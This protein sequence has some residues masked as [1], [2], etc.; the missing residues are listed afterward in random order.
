MLTLFREVE[1]TTVALETHGLGLTF[2]VPGMLM[3][4]WTP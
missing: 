4:H 3:K 2:P 1:A